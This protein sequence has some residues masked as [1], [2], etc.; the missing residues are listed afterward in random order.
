M[1]GPEAVLRIRF[2][3][4]FSYRMPISISRA[5]L[6]PDELLAAVCLFNLFGLGA[7]CLGLSI[8]EAIFQNVGYHRVK[9]AHGSYESL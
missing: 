6:R 8:A 1:I 7:N 4:I 3:I 9:E 5:K 2:G